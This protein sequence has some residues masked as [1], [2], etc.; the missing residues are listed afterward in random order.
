MVDIKF[1][2]RFADKFVQS[3]PELNQELYPFSKRVQLID[4]AKEI[5]S[6]LRRAAKNEA[7]RIALSDLLG[8]FFGG[9]LVTVSDTNSMDP[10]I[11]AGHQ[12]LMVPF[13]EFPPFRREDLQVGDIVLFDRLLDGTKDVLHRI[14]EIKD[15]GRI[16][17]TRGD[18][19]TVLDGETAK[20]KLKYLCVGVIY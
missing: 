14:E 1:S 20:Q 10:W 2:S 5:P 12:A 11:D 13:Q 16:V 18:N 3:V 15:D 7:F 4:N 9:F 17:I 19:T 6:P 8:R